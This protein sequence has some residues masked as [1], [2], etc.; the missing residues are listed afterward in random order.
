MAKS[1]AVNRAI[2]YPYCQQIMIRTVMLS[3]QFSQEKNQHLSYLI[4]SLHGEVEDS[5]NDLNHERTRR[6]RVERNRRDAVR[7][8]RARAWE[9]G[10]EEVE[11]EKDEP[12][13]KMYASRGDDACRTEGSVETFDATSAMLDENHL[14]EALG[15]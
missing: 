8:S 4:L 2:L 5:Q 3:L 1:T 13:Q 6:E 9:A 7:G 11:Q 10:F 12:R 14:Y 15:L